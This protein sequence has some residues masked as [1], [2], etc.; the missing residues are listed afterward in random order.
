MFQEC[1]NSDSRAYYF[2]ASYFSACD[3]IGAPFASSSSSP[4]LVDAEK[5]AALTALRLTTDK[6]DAYKT[7]VEALVHDI[8]QARL[9]A[10]AFALAAQSRES[11]LRY[12]FFDKSTA[13]SEYFESM[14]PVQTL[15]H[16][17]VQC[18]G[19][20]GSLMPLFPRS[21]IL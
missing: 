10:A 4:S 2:D 13:L 15:K 19:N 5:T 9:D 20:H 14:F 18:G 11:E 17:S 12:G 21:I 8:E 6:C 1:E 16:F 3:P 7:R